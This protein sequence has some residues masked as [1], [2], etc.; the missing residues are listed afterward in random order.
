[1]NDVAVTNALIVDTFREAL[2]RKVFWAFF[3]SSTALLIFFLLIMRIDV[4]QGMVASVTIFGQGGNPRGGGMSAEDMVRS[5]QAGLSTFLYSVGMGLAIFASAGLISAVFE[6]GR[7]ELLLSKPVTRHHILLGRY[8]G[9]FLIVAAN[10]FYLVLGFWLIF[11]FKTGVWRPHLLLAAAVTLAIFAVLLGFILLTAVLYESAAVSILATF[12]LVVLSLVLA[13]K[14]ML[15]RLLSSEWSR[16]L[17]GALYYLFP[18]I[19]DNA[20]IMMNIIMAKPVDSWMPLW[21][22]ALF[23][24]VVLSGGLL[25]FSRRNF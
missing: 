16:K 21:S 23:G 14:P 7:V 18:K 1:M 4:V 8:L 11:G 12:A 2:A 15:E 19:P 3:F 24:V 13:A 10:L 5:A 6:P 9:N 17:V 25:I 22:T 20:K